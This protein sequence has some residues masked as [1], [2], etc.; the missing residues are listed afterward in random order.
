MEEIDPFAEAVTRLSDEGLALEI[1][2]RTFRLVDPVRGD[3]GAAALRLL[4]MVQ[5]AAPVA[6]ATH[7][8]TQVAAAVWAPPHLYVV[9]W[10]R[11]RWVVG[12]RLAAGSRPNDHV[13]SEGR[14][15]G[16]L[17]TGHWY[18]TVP[19]EVSETFDGVGLSLASA[20]FPV[21]AQPVSEAP[22]SPRRSASGSSGRS[23]AEKAPPARPAPRRIAPKPA[24]AAKAPPPP[25]SKVCP[26]CN[27]RRTLT[28]FAPG[29]DLCVD[30]RE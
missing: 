10:A 7:G 22:V 5:A 21:P 16:H 4:G 9:R 3:A 14:I 24:P 13:R 28:Q 15:P 2:G 18:E 1:T 23:S 20:P 17:E 30:C 8:P 25:T 19:D 6:I 27:M 29:S 26:G 11:N 12:Y